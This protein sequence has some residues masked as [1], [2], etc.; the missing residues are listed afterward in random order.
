MKT[1]LKTLL[2]AGAVLFGA[3]HP[4]FALEDPAPKA[5]AEALKGKRIMLVPMAMGFDLAQGWEAYLKREI[6]AF[7]G[8]L[9]TQTRTGRWRRAPRPSPRRF[10]PRRSPMC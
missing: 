10:P 9:E 5:Y 6:D 7:G 3:L 8:V 2:T 4:A 1:A